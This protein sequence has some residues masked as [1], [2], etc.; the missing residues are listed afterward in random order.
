MNYKEID[1]IRKDANMSQDKFA[2]FLEI[3]KRTYNYRLTLDQAR[4]LN[5]IIK[6]SSL[7]KGKIRVKTKEGDYEIAIKKVELL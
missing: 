3:S 6:A 5:D 7:N 2:E 4:T 1:E